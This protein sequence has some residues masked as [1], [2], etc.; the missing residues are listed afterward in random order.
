MT[1][2]CEFYYGYAIGCETK[3]ET[4]RYR[5]CYYLSGS[6]SS[7]Q[8]VSVVA[9]SSLTNDS[10]YT[11]PP[12]SEVRIQICKLLLF[13]FIPTIFGE[14]LSNFSTCSLSK[15]SAGMESGINKKTNIKP[16]TLDILISQP[17]PIF[18]LIK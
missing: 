2:L 9:L 14:L 11:N 7:K 16:Y 8:I 17:N 15:T 18:L 6:L 13:V 10:H 5:Q 12:P 4:I 1:D 3:W